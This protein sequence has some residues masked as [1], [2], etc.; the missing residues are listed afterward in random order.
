M[1]KKLNFINNSHTSG[2]VNPPEVIHHFADKA[3]VNAVAH[4]WPD[5]WPP[6]WLPPAPIGRL[7]AVDASSEQERADADVSKQ[8]LHNERA[9]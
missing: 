1:K 7:K 2:D 8:Q 6:D 9:E 3:N 5:D 4:C